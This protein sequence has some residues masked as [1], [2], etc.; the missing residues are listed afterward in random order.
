[1]ELQLVTA[2]ALVQMVVLSRHGPVK[3]RLPTMRQLLHTPVAST[4][5]SA[6]QVEILKDRLGGCVGG[7]TTLKSS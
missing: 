2:T 3:P 6:Q 5:Q 1:M 4:I 7:G